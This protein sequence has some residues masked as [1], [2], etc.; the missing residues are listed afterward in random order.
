MPRLSDAARKNLEEY[1]RGGGGLAFF[2]GPSI[3]SDT[4]DEYNEK[5]YRKGEGCSRSRSTSWSA[6]TCRTTSGSPSGSAACSRSTR[7][8]SSAGDMQNHPALESSTRTTAGRRSRRTS[9]RS[10]ST[11]WSSTATSASTSS[12]SAARPGGVET[13]VYLQN[14]KPIDNY[15]KAVNDL[16]DQLQP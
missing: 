4:I 3:K 16:T 12:S 2:M 15:T 7:S 10:S 6:W 11:S 8:C 13:L 9:T 14:T 5:L 1:V